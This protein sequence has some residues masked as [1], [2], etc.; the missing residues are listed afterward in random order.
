[1]KI[2]VELDEDSSF[3]SEE[4]FFHCLQ[5]LID[6]WNDESLGL[7]PKEMDETDAGF[8]CDRFHELKSFLERK[9]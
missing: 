1:M 7:G 4:H 6:E 9:G 2:K 3:N 5:D 8:N